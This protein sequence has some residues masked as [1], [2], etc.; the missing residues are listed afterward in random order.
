MTIRIQ[1]GT[2]CHE[3]RES[4]KMTRYEDIYLK[5]KE[6]HDA[7]KRVRFINQAVMRRYEGF[8]RYWWNQL[9]GRAD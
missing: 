5:A 9:T 4:L 7:G 1:A 3:S 2:S 8:W 6:I